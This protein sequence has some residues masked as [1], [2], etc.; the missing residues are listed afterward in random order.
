MKERFKHV[1]ITTDDLESYQKHGLRF[2]QTPS[3]DFPSITTILGGTADKSWLDSWKTSLG[4]SKAAAETKRCAERGT[5]VHLIC[6]RYLQNDPDY[7]RGQ[8]YENMKL[9]NQIKIHLHK[10]NNITGQEIALYS[11]L[12]RIAGRC[13]VIGEYDG[14]LSIIDF[15]TSNGNKEKLM[16]ED[17]FLQCTAYSLMYEEMFGI[18][19]DQIVVIITVE[20]GLSGQ[21]FKRDRGPYIAPLIKRARKFHESRKQ[22]G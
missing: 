8:R 19:I 12:L 11:E 15:K 14:K 13:D 18:T 2:Y 6:E 9:F 1:P 3:G 5:A 17:Y 20:K 10:I 16:I 21:V 22:K 4:E 7:D